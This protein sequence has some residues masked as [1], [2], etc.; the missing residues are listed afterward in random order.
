DA[1]LDAALLVAPRYGHRPWLEAVVHGEC[2]QQRVEANRM[3]HALEHGALEIVV[4]DDVRHAAPL[5]EC[6]GVP[7]EEVL[8]LLP[9]VETKEDPTREGKHDHEGDQSSNGT[10][11]R[12]FAEVTPVDL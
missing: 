6:R 9:D 1:P 7:A 2:E 10:A 4:E 3:A 5:G 11:D 12:E 8:G